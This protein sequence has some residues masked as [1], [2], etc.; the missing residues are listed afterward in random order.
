MRIA[1]DEKEELRADN[2]WVAVGA[3]KKKT[4]L[5]CFSLLICC[6]NLQFYYSFVGLIKGTRIVQEGPHDRKKHEGIH[7][8]KRQGIRVMLIKH[9]FGSK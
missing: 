9:I 8:L 1:R 5:T 6:H 2:L 3:V 4:K 7:F